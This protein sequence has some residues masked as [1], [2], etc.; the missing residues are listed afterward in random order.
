MTTAV[1]LKS[2]RCKPCHGETKPL[3]R[4]EADRLL[5]MIPGWIL[6]ANG[7]YLYRTWKVRDFMSGLR[8]F[9]KVAEV[10][11]TEDHHPDLHLENYRDATIRLT[12]HAIKGLSENDF[13][14]AAKISDLPVELKEAK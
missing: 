7:R 6:D 1:N 5:T 10:A 4:N 3:A 2:K 14:L 12:T 13:I 8:F 9:Q 11:E